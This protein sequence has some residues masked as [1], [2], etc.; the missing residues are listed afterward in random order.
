M[1]AMETL[2]AS[3]ELQMSLLLF[4]ALP[5]GKSLMGAFVDDAGTWSA[6]ALAERLGQAVEKAYRGKREY[7]HLDDKVLLSWNA[8][9]IG[10]RSGFPSSSMGMSRRTRW[11]YVARSFSERVSS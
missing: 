3:T 2:L 1:F 7:P 8:L 4:V 6:G 11:A 9:M 10:A 5:V